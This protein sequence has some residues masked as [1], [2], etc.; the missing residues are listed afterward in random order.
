MTGFDEKIAGI[1]HGHPGADDVVVQ[2][3]VSLHRVFAQ[4]EI[5]EYSVSVMGKNRILTE[6]NPEPGSKGS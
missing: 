6:G 5:R 4:G 1:P 2:N 3:N